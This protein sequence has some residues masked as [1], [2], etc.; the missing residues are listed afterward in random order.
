MTLSLSFKF[1][2]KYVM[3]EGIKNLLM[4][5]HTMLKFKKTWRLLT[6]LGTLIMFLCSPLSTMYEFGRVEF[7]Q[8]E[9]SQNKFGR[10]EFGQVEFGIVEFCRGEFDGFPLIFCLI[11]GE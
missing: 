2:N 9:F 1:H 8:V 7:G 6:E 10:V 5:D 11:W 3:F 4:K